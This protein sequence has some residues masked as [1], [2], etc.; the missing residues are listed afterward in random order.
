ML[1][2]LKKISASKY[3]SLWIILIIA[4]L[5]RLFFLRFEYAVGWDEVNYLKLGASG[6]INGFSHVLHPYWSPLYPL[7]V[8]IFGKLN[9]DFELAGRLVSILFGALLIVPIYLFTIKYLAQKT[10][11]F[12]C[13]LIALFPSLI[14]SSVSALTEA[15]YICLGITGVILGYLAIQ[16]KSI[17]LA[18]TVGGLF[19]MA[20]LTRPE[21]AGFLIVFGGVTLCGAT[22]QLIKKHEFR[23]FKV[24]FVSII[25][26][27][28]ISSPYL[29][30]LHRVTGKWTLS[31]KGPA[32]MQG[33]ITV[34]ENKGKNVN[35][36]LLLSE[37]NTTL[38]DDEI[39]HTGNFL[40]NYRRNNQ[41]ELQVSTRNIVKVTPFL[42]LKKYVKNFLEVITTGISQ[43]LSLPIIALMV[44]GLWSKPWD[45]EHT[46][47]EMYLLSYV[48]FFWFLVIPMFHITERYML[49]MV[50]IILIWSGVG[51]ERLLDWL[52]QTM[53]SSKFT[54]KKNYLYMLQT[55][56]VFLFV[57]T[58]IIS[59]WTQMASKN[60]NSTEKWAEPVEQ[61]K[62]GLWLKKYCQQTPIIMAWN[63]AISF[64]AGN[65]DIK[66]SV[67]IPRNELDRVLTYARNR[68][69]K[70]LA[71]NEKNKE[72]FPTINYLLDESQ[73]PPELKLIYKDDSVDGLKAIIYE[74]LPDGLGN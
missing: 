22:Y 63:H 24:L 17:G 58:F 21:G 38:P 67:S 66:Q 12:C 44:L 43:V 6:A 34:M 59:A 74:I 73:A 15:L 5:V 42:I 20:Y 25:A 10:V 50:P 18:I 36:W 53:S 45:W 71:L 35:P 54:F 13:L 2:L 40:K 14:D 19:G 3:S 60:P 16:K 48:I 62:A 68:G 46:W 65:Y 70:Y 57:G 27:V 23:L 11:Y 47:R 29:Y 4:L 41:E 64:Y 52:N 72:N 30:Y 7:F 39:Y 9:T 8:A 61:K 1:S 55:I 31:S 49:S 37:D 51:I 26:F 56:L 32:N 33:E 69:A 28:V